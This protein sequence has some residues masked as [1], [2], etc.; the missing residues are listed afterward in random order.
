MVCHYNYNS[1]DHASTSIDSSLS[2]SRTE[3]ST[4]SSTQSYTSSIIRNYC[5]D[6]NPSYDQDFPWL[7]NKSQTSFNQSSI[8]S[9]ISSDIHTIRRFNTDVISSNNIHTFTTKSMQKKW[10]PWTTHKIWLMLANTLLFIYGLACFMLGICTYCKLYLRAIIFLI[11]ERT[12]ANLITIT[13]CICLC[14]SL[15]GYTGIVLHHRPIL[16]IYNLLLWICLGFIA[17]IGYYSYRRMKWNIEGKLSYQWHYQLSSQDRATIQANLHCCGYKIYSDFHETSN[18]CYPR[19]LYPGCRSKYLNL[20]KGLL[21]NAWTIAFSIVPVHLAILIS[22]LLCSNH[23]N[24][25]FGKGLPPYL[26]H[27]NYNVAMAPIS[28]V[29]VAHYDDSTTTKSDSSIRRRAY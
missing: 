27:V 8:L 12:L 20:I 24:N 22:A 19:T 10:R 18:K 4:R 26:Y 28:S 7:W 16:A 11:G 15:L 6:N 21:K 9:S 13:G 17:S 14:T 29:D 2:P 5:I 23:V 1:K 3:L 25:T